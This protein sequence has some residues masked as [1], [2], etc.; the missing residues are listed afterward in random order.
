MA[1]PNIL[2]VDTYEPDKIL[3]GLQAAI[4]STIKASINSLGFA[5]YKW[6]DAKGNQRQWERKQAMEA[7][8]DL[9]AVE[10]QIN[11]ELATCDEL[12]LVVEGIALPTTSGVQGYKLQRYISGKTF[13]QQDFHYPMVDKGMRPQPGLYAKYLAWKQG[14]TYAGVQV[15]ET[16][17]MDATIAVLATAYTYSQREEHTTLKRYL[18]PHV[19]PFSP[20][21]H[22]DN[23]ARL[24]NTGIGL[25]KAQKLIAETHTFYGAVTAIPEFQDQVLG[26]ATGK[27]FRE[28]I[29]RP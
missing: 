6:M 18:T 8:T 12:V 19:P 2:F 11:Y 3:H 1:S 14:I 21:P 25:V 26:A 16:V 4:P 24:K 10:D 27:K 5:D 13:L 28:V 22:I 17:D 20:N 29:G 23:L 15:V 7:I 9:D